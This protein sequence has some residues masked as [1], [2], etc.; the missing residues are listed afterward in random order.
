MIPLLLVFLNAPKMGKL[1]MCHIEIK[2]R[3]LPDWNLLRPLTSNATKNVGNHYFWC[4]RCSLFG[5]PLRCKEKFVSK[6]LFLMISSCTKFCTVVLSGVLA[7]SFS[8]SALASATPTGGA[9]VT[10]SV[11]SPLPPLPPST[12][13][14]I[15]MASVVSPLPPLPPSTGGATTTASVVSPL[16]PLPPSTGGVATMASVVSPLPPLPPSTGGVATTA[17]VVSPLPPLP[18]S[19]GG[20]IIG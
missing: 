13:G 6:E 4:S 8:Y 3:P 15:T 14:V 10:A 18:P 17:S 12:G 9:T 11:V 16:P 1:R 2:L 5:L 20:V 7:I 19:T